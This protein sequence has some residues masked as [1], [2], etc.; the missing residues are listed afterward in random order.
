MKIY[1]ELEKKGLWKEP[2]QIDAGPWSSGFLSF[3]VHGPLHWTV[4]PDPTSQAFVIN[5][6]P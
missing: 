4:F 2:V 6:E 5:Q 1:L 3:T